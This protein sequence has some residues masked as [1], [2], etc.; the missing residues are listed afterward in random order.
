MRH[1][2]GDAGKPR[3]IRQIDDAVPQ[4]TEP[5]GDARSVDRDAIALNRP[6]SSLL[7]ERLDAHE[8]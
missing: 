3:H 8:I 6:A 5:V 4:L 7:R 2:N 1:R